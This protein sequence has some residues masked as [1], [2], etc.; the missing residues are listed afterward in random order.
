MKPGS[1]GGEL[2]TSLLPGTLGVPPP[3]AFA[4]LF[5]GFIFVTKGTVPGRLAPQLWML[6]DVK[7][8]LDIC[9][10]NI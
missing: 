10:Y 2:L 3:L 8:L 1:R 9:I 7:I 6:V 4:G 5:G